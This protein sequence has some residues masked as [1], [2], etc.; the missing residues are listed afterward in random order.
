MKL[1]IERAALLRSL[2][3]VQNV[4]ERRTTIPILSNVKLAAESDRLGL[5][6][7]DM[8]LSLVAHEPAAVARRGTTTVAAHTLFDIVRK[9]PDGSEIG[10]EQG[11]GG[12]MTVRAA[13]SVFNLPTLPADEFPAIGE[14]Q[15]GVSFTMPVSDLARLIDKTRFA[16]S[17]EETRYYLNGIHV[18]ATSAGAASMLRGVA[19]DGHRLARVE[20]A[21][22]AGAEKIP[23]IIIPRKTVG[24]VRKLIDSI[25]GEVE[26]S[27]SATRIQFAFER[28][29]LVSRLI[30]G[31]FPDYE[32]VIPTGNEKM[33]IF[34]TAD[35]GKAVDRV[36][37]IS[38]EKARAVKLGFDDGTV[39][40]SAVSAETGR[41]EEEL[42]VDY[43]SESLEI[44]FNARYILDMLQEID[45]DTVRFEMASAAAPTVA[46]DPGDSST[47]YVLMPMRV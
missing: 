15:L 26:I 18:H 10:I 46:R 4:V 41:A 31:T 35:L 40:V 25:G 37:T 8:D 33:A 24:E 36:A 1:T 32:R 23:A 6:A 30:D 27:V 19:T 20:V 3:H 47:L 28:A 22:P 14:E 5:T 12:E 7:T 16:I 45:G 44:G 13:R 38:T 39:R 29:V 21:L 17:T 34:R 2:A 43:S 11:D 42:D 9:L